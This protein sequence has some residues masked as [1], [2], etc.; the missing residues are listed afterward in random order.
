MTNTGTLLLLILPGDG[1][2][3]YK[4]ELV[5]LSCEWGDCQI[6]SSIRLHHFLVVS[7]V[8]LGRI[9]LGESWFGFGLDEFSSVISA[10]G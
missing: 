9:L 4:T 7:V 10:H 6:L 2:R 5:W 8:A 3:N 1:L